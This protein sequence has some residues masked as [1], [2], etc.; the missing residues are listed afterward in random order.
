MVNVVPNPYKGTSLFEPRYEAQIMFTH[1]PPK[2]KISIF[3]LTGDLVQEFEHND[4][5]Y[6]DILWNLITRNNQAVVSGLYLYVV[7]TENHKK[8]GK[9]LIIR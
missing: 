3:T 8:V 1:L 4:S 7:E 5:D 6:G 2:C 9:M